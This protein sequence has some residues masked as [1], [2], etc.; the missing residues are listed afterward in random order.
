MPAKQETGHERMRRKSSARKGSTGSRLQRGESSCAPNASGPSLALVCRP[1]GVSQRIHHL[2]EANRALES[3]LA[4]LTLM[5]QQKP[6]E[7]RDSLY[8]LDSVH[9]RGESVFADG[10]G[11]RSARS[12]SVGFFPASASPA[13]L[14]PNETALAAHNP[15]YMSLPSCDTRSRSRSPRQ[16]L[17]CGTDSRRILTPVQ[18]E[19]VVAALQFA[20]ESLMETERASRRLLEESACWSVKACLASA[21]YVL[22][23]LGE[24][25]DKVSA[26]TALVDDLALK[27]E[28]YRAAMR[29]RFYEKE[30]SRRLDVAAK[31]R[32]A[33]AT[34]YA[35]PALT[36]NPKRKLLIRG[37]RRSSSS[38]VREEEPSSPLSVTAGDEAS[39]LVFPVHPAVSKQREYDWLQC[40]LRE[41]ERDEADISLYNVHLKQEVD[42][43]IRQRASQT[44]DPAKYSLPAEL[45]EQELPTLEQVPAIQYAGRF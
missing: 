36:S 42:R 6:S 41:L 39:E 22:T 45:Q 24:L 18:P 7:T 13:H 34:V 40:K 10:A 11:H 3:Q 27:M 28:E 4:G 23:N 19:P 17:Y 1:D 2:E 25:C 44:L 29:R 43:Q 26:Q 14:L 15:V 21:T 8:H 30:T 35:A 12:P 37:T 16:A 31:D 5:F 20:L 33:A 9:Q 38:S 32:V